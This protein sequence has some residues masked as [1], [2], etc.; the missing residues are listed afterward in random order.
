MRFVTLA[1]LFFVSLN[2]QGTERKQFLHFDKSNDFPFNLVDNIMQDSHGYLWVGSSTGLAR[3][4]GYSFEVYTAQDKKVGLPSNR[5]LC[6]F[7]AS[8]GD[9]LVGTNLG[10]AA[11]DRTLN[12][13]DL[14]SYSCTADI[15]E[16]KNHQLWVST[17]DGMDVR[18]AKTLAL[19]TSFFTEK[20]SQVKDFRG[21]ILDSFGRVWAFTGSCGIYVFNS[22]TNKLLKHIDSKLISN[23]DQLKLASCVFDRRGQLWIGTDGNGLFCVDTATFKVRN[24]EA[25][26]SPSSIGSNN[27]SCVYADTNDDIW[28]CCQNGYLNR[29]NRQNGTFQRFVPQ[30]DN[31]RYLNASSVLCINQDRSGNYWIGTYGYGIYCLSAMYNNFSTFISLPGAT[32]GTSVGQV[33]SFAELDN[34]TIALSTD[35]NGIKLYNPADNSIRPFAGNSQLG[36]QNVLRLIRR[37]NALWGATWGGGLFQIDLKSNRVT[38]YLH[39]VNKLSSIN[40][41]N[42]KGLFDLDTALAVGTHGD[43]LAFY[44]YKKNTFTHKNNAKGPAFDPSI[45]AWI[46]DVTRD[47]RGN[48]WISTYYGLYKLAG[49]KLTHYATNASDHKTINSMEVLSVFEDR[50]KRLWALTTQGLDSYS[51]DNDNFTR[52]SELYCLPGD[53]R[54]VI[55]DKEGCIWLCTADKL[56]KIS[57]M[58]KTSL[59][60][61][62]NDGIVTGEMNVNASF[63]ASDGTLYFGSTEGFMTC[64]PS[65]MSM[66]RTAPQLHFRNLLVNYVKQSPDSTFLQKAFDTSDTLRYAYTEDVV[67]IELA[68]IQF[69]LPNMIDYAYSFGGDKGKWLNLG[70]ERTISF[71]A[72]KPGTYQL[73]VKATMENGLSSQRVLTII[74]VPKWWMTWWFRSIIALMMVAFI[75]WIIYLR[76]QKIKNKNIELEI[77]VKERTA[78]LQQAN[79]SLTEKSEELLHQAQSL[80]WQNNSLVEKHLVIEMKNDQLEEALNAKDWLIG[81]IAHDFKNP[82]FSI[83]SLSSQLKN[84]LE[85]MPMDKIVQN[86]DSVYSATAKLKEQMMAVLDWAQGQIQEVNYLPVEINIETIIDDAIL[87]V[88]E[89]SKQKNISIAVQYAFQANA[90]VDP[91]M[92]STVMRNLLINAIKFT[93]HGGRISI[94]VQEYDSGIEVNV[95]DTGVGMDKNLILNLFNKETAASATASRHEE[96]IG[97]GLQICKKYIEKNSGTISVTSKEGEGTVFTVTVPKGKSEATRKHAP[98]LS[99]AK[100]EAAVIEGISF[101]KNTALTVLV[102]DDD[103][104]IALVIQNVLEPYYTVMTASDGNAG[105]QLA[106]NMVPNLIISDLNMPNIDGM[107]LCR[108]LKNDAMTNH[109]PIILITSFSANGLEVDAYMNGAD[110]FV[111]KPFDRIALLYKVKLFLDSTAK[112]PQPVKSPDAEQFILPES[113]DDAI[114]RRIMELLNQ[115]L[116]DAHFDVD[117]IASSIGLSRT[118]LWRKTKSTLDKTPGELIRDMRMKKAAEMLKTGKYRVSEV[119]YSVGYNDPRVF[120]RN[121]ANEFGMSP[122]EFQKKHAG[123]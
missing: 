122:S 93:P 51:Y 106:R 49:G 97:L 62:K 72:L 9:I 42:I 31:A 82:L 35:G 46:N 6:T 112:D 1:L 41:N 21:S 110:D 28:A 89:S 3:Y 102:I 53:T 94:L 22:R 33:T 56:I 121:F 47:S 26:A 57:G 69:G 7:E 86:V 15:I 98:A 39:D 75:A 20:D 70:R 25:S 10:M 81:I 59:I 118:Q 61:D 64:R 107:E 73:T 29:L 27:V 108:L 66:S 23:I 24:Y 87:L 80:E 48:L 52:I 18:D 109:V 44:N 100:D 91:R 36:S 32:G 37:G 68:A 101:E 30:P 4:D 60:Y 95:I 77:L 12:S 54:S 45:N 17:Y 13:F 2:V 71:T 8:G 43:G 117:S 76:T 85:R 103:P 123:E 11:Y 34:G 40:L 74:V 19:K 114:V 65:S 50:S 90:F 55:E 84:N 92:V 5:I 79:A 38:N 63:R 119:A 99:A 104:E 14:L 96:G 120:M 105:L 16:D 113:A 88:R 115:N 58:N 83:L 111:E 116:N 78:E 67:S